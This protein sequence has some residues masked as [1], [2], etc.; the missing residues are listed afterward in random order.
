[1][2]RG[3]LFTRAHLEEVSDPSAPGAA[4]FVRGLVAARDPYLPW[5]IRQ[6]V[7]EPD[8]K[9]ANAVILEELEGGATEISLRVD[10]NGETGVTIRT[11]DEM[12]T[13]LDAVMLDL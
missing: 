13:A 1:V 3:P 4:P 6:P 2:A 10:P 11:L 8:P 9:K 5:G 7:D 12:K